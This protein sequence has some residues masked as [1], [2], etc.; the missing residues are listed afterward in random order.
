MIVDR[1]IA[2]PSVHKRLTGKYMIDVFG[3]L[4]EATHHLGLRGYVFDTKVWALV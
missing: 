4:G 1:A 2:N 3:G